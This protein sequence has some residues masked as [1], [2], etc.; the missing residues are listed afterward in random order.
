MLIRYVGT[1]TQRVFGPYTFKPQTGRECVVEGID[2][3]QEML[4]QPGVDF[5]VSPDDPLAK[6]VGAERAAELVVLEGVTTPDDYRQRYGPPGAKVFV[7]EVGHPTESIQ[8]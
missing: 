2:L 7:E 5:A 8:L 4:T 1:S 3:L 6:L